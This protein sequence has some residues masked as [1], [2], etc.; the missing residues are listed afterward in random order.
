M[1]ARA[2]SVTIAAIVCLTAMPAGAGELL[3][4]VKVA[5]GEQP[6]DVGRIGHS[7]P[8]VGDFDGDGLDDLLVGEF[9]DGRLRIYRNG[10]TRGQ[11]RFEDYVWFEAGREPGRVPSG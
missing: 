9:Y 7:A 2:L 8:F 11:P 3:P 5:A 4:P 6:I 10:G 1:P